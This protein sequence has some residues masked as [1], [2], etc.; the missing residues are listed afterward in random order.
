MLA[1]RS[2]DLFL[3][4]EATDMMKPDVCDDPM[5]QV[6]F[7][8]SSMMHLAPPPPPPS[9]AA[10]AAAAA[11]DASSSSLNSV[12]KD[13]KRPRQY[14]KK[15]CPVSTMSSV[16]KDKEEVCFHLYMIIYRKMKKFIYRNHH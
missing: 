6:A 8:S 5:M 3:N 9:A 2:Q 16:N 14:T 7:S 15:D 1:S 10:A 13:Q 4:D 11:L 12:E